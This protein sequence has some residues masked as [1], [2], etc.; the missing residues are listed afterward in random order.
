MNAEWSHFDNFFCSEC[1]N[2]HNQITTWRSKTNISL[3]KFYLNNEDEDFQPYAAL[4]MYLRNGQLYDKHDREVY[5]IGT[6]RHFAEM[7]RL[8][9]PDSNVPKAEI[10]FDHSEQI[11][12]K[13]YLDQYGWDTIRIESQKIQRPYYY[14]P[15]HQIADEIKSPSSFG[16]DAD[17]PSILNVIEDLAGSGH[18]LRYTDSQSQCEYPGELGEWIEFFNM[19]NKQSER[20]G[21]NNMI[22]KRFNV[23][24]MEFT[25]ERF[26]DI[27]M[28][29]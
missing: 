16:P 3:R 21:H 19:K 11:L 25:K 9:G 8:Y 29:K 18:M 7:L 6:E 24:S 17:I 2:K 26:S 22:N 10:K 28:N 5:E 14:R 27:I 13:E 1:E 15:G 12:T 23:I 4:G 20:F